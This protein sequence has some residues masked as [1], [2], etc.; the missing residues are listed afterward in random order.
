MSSVRIFRN[1]ET[2]VQYESPDL[3][4]PL[5]VPAV[6]L[7]GRRTSQSCLVGFRSLQFHSRFGRMQFLRRCSI[8]K[9]VQ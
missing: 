7:L 2:E 4:A 1:D 9:A 8:V 5:K 6:V 3:P